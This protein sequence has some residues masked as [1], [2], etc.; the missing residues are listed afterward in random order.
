MTPREIAALLGRAEAT[1][2]DELARL[3]GAYPD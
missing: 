2:R 1:G 3:I